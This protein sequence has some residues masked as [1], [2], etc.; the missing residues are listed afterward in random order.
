[1]AIDPSD[2]PH[3]AAIEQLEQF[4]LS[5]YAARTFVA[6]VRLGTATAAEV[7]D[8]SDVPRTRVYDAVDE[9]QDRD[10]VDVQQSSP[11][12]FLA[13]S[14]ETTRRKFQQEL[15]DRMSTLTAALD[16]L[17]PVRRVEEQRGVWTVDGRDATTDRV[18]EFI[19]GAD[20]EIVYMTVENLL[21]GRVLDA[22]CAAA[23]RDVSIEIGG[24]S[25]A[26]DE[27]IRA[28]V[29]G[30]ERFG[31]LWVWSDTP[32]GRLVMADRKRTLVSVL[33]N[34]VDAD[35]AEPRSETA[36]RG[37]GETNSLV[38]VLRAIFAWQLTGG[39]DLVE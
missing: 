10:L 23:D 8:V 14:T 26:V 9:L 33:V 19:D 17:E 2:D 30:A 39:D 18:I 38:V 22:L 16:E 13:I 12:A 31:S 4:G 35:P 21:T 1:M 5:A 24:G 20:D 6:L 7:N 25:T 34:G 36:I 3:A 28:N 29:P 15:D 11:V 37:A 27:R 32:A